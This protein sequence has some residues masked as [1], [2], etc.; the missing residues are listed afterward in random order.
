TAVKPYMFAQLRRQGY[1]RVIY[2]DPDILL[3]DRL[4]D[5]ERLL[6]EGASAVV[7][8]HLTAPIDDGHHPTELDIM[9]AGAYNL[10]FLA[11]AGTPAADAFI[12]WWQDKLEHGAVSDT[13]RGLFTDQK[14]VD[15]APGMF[16]G[17]AVLR[18]PGY[19]VAYWNL[20]HRPVTR[21]NGVWMAGGSRLRFFHFSGFDPNNPKPFSKH[22]DRLNLNTIGEARELAL[23]YAAKVLGHDYVLF[24]A[25]PYAF[26]VFED[27]IPIPGVIRALYRE[28]DELRFLVGDN[29]FRS[30][31]FFAQGESGGLPTILRALW[32][33][34][35]HLQRAFPDPL[36]SSREAYY[37]WFTD[38]G[39]VEA[40]IHEVFVREV[41]SSLHK[42]LSVADYMPETP[43][44]PAGRLPSNASL[45]A[46]G[47]VYLHKRATGGK[48]SA[49]RLLQ[50]QQ[51]TGPLQFL[52]LC[53]R[54]VRGMRWLA[55]FGIHLGVEA[56][57]QDPMRAAVAVAARSIAP[58]PL[59]RSQ[60]YSGL[61]A[62]PGKEVWWVGRHAK[63][64][65]QHACGTTL[66]LRG[67]HMG[68]LHQRSYGGDSGLNI[69]IGIGEEPRVTVRVPSGPFDVTVELP[70]QPKV[71]PSVLHVI[72]E[73]S[74]V[75]SEIGLGSDHRR[76]SIQLA[77]IE[78]GDFCVFDATQFGKVV[79]GEAAINGHVPLGVPGLNVIGYARSEHGVGQ[80]LR[81]F[82]AALDAGGIPCA[83][84]DFNHNNLS[85]VQ[86]R[87][88]EQRIVAEPEHRINVFHIN[89][90]QMPE[91]EMHLPAH[92]FARYN[93]GFWHWELPEMLEEHL[94]GF[95]RLNE[96][97][98][99]TAFVQD[100]VAKKSPVPVVR[101]PHAIQFSVSE[102]ASR[103]QFG[104]PEDKFLFLMMYD[105]SS[106]QER[107][108]PQAAL[109]AFE[110]AFAHANDKVALVIKTHNAQFHDKDVQALRDRIAG[111]ADVI[112]INET[113]SR[114]QVYDLQSVCDALVSLHRSEGYGLGPAEAMFL[115]KPVIAT[116]W[117]GN[118]EFMRPYNSLPV[119]Y[120]LVEI[121]K[122]VGVYRAGQIWAEPDVAHAALQM[123]RVVEDD[124]LR[125]N[126]SAEARRTMREEFSPEAIGKRIKARLAFIQNKLILN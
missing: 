7:T 35:E 114:Q 66:N 103:A 65:L 20:P 95:N 10:G 104:L 126:I 13:K 106:Y 83:I 101:M 86:D 62:E 44:M 105:F 6:D 72:P 39:G 4:E 38:A 85:R 42:L 120:R 58:A 19:N 68:D 115:G 21:E 1:E 67:I 108:N 61:Y 50:Y 15:L 113:L 48:L 116:D 74:F 94:A 122:D 93:I 69:A 14:W 5:V 23:E 36:G 26:G 18:D 40:G 45:W 110:Q 77:S 79:H 43:K 91:A 99:P 84:M 25:K 53:F 117:S 90:D 109:A 121:Q 27:G 98:V 76:L 125:A 52:R 9:S 55:R 47:L 73:V 63:F 89:A 112:W 28:D 70:H 3:V 56:R 60:A 78:L 102:N 2:I 119:N 30:G 75:P 57:R 41:A 31:E 92:I 37:R 100:A 49:E 97:W 46:R 59:W 88:L 54:Q 16:G 51:V 8:P 80:S 64:Q 123:R 29:P 12:D 107:K 33:R 81:Q 82:T 22:Q 118:T 111:R 32:L 96:V 87:S 34:Q 124:A 17:F 71:W 24:R 11:I